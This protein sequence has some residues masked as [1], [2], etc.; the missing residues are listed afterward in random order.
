MDSQAQNY[1]KLWRYSDLAKFL[2][3]SE[4]KLRRDVA[5]GLIPSIKI[6]HSVRFSRN[7]IEDYFKIIIQ[8]GEESST[9]PINK[10]H[11]SISINDTVRWLAEKSALFPFAEINIRVIIHE[12]RIKRIERTVTEKIQDN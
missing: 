9:I 12:G 1:D 8:D 7:Q 4:M 5:K 2:Q 11:K 10:H 3:V 6:G